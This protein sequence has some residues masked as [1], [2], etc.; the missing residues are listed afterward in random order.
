MSKL[1][2]HVQRLLTMYT[3]TKVWLC[4]YVH[5]LVMSK[6]TNIR[7]QLN[8]VSDKIVYILVNFFYKYML[9]TQILL[10]VLTNN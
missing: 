10:D 7:T 1:C 4:A 8:A 6:L 2:T 9:N 5:Y 3:C